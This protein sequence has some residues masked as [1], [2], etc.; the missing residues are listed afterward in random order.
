MVDLLSLGAPYWSKVL[1][2]FGGFVGLMM[3]MGTVY[4]NY[5]V[6]RLLR[7]IEENTRSKP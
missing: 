2:A 5:K 3:F 1:I 6:R 4:H 7:L